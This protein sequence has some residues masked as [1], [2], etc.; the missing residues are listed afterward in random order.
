MQFQIGDIV[1]LKSGGPDLTVIGFDGGV[2]RVKYV[3]ESEFPAV[4]L[5]AKT[6][7]ASASCTSSASCG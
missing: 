6:S 2:V 7:P 1:H 3:T 4:C 5:L